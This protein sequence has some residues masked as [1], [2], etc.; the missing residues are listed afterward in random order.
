[1]NARHVQDTLETLFLLKY[2]VF[3][4]VTYCKDFYRLGRACPLMSKALCARGMACDSGYQAMQRHIVELERFVARLRAS[5]VRTKLQN[6]CML[7]A[8]FDIGRLQRAS[9]SFNEY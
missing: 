2:H 1:M 9:L 3:P 5:D 7:H 8:L 6:E 4:A